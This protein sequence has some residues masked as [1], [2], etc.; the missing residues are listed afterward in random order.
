MTC[1]MRSDIIVTTVWGLW[2]TSG[3][4]V[5]AY[6][7]FLNDNLLTVI[8][9]INVGLTISLLSMKM[10]QHNMENCLNR[11]IEDFHTEFDY[12]PSHELYHNP[13]LCS[14]I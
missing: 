10:W 11:H 7:I 2:S 9:G 4:F 14:R 8:S 3:I 1:N 12:D 5:F 13:F 6:S